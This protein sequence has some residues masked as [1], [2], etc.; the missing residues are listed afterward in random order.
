MCDQIEQELKLPSFRRDGEG[1]RRKLI[2]YGFCKKQLETPPDQ[3]WL[4]QL[5]A[6]DLCL[7]QIIHNFIFHFAFLQFSPHT[8]K[9]TSC[10]GHTTAEQN[11]ICPTGALVQPAVESGFFL[12]W[13]RN[14]EKRT[15]EESQVQWLCWRW[16]K[17]FF[18]LVPPWSL[19]RKAQ[20]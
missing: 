9:I 14:S 18:P 13:I 1:W 5:L 17:E 19:P 16:R 10:I 15:T 3:R 20:C 2:I 7:I 11:Q 8:V 12:L 4:L 6:M